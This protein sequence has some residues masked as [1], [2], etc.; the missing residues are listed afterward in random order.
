VA[1]FLRWLHNVI[2]G[3]GGSGQLGHCNETP[4]LPYK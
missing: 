3:V 2:V 4:D 1:T